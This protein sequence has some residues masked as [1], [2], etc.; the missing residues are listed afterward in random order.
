MVWFFF[1]LNLEDDITSLLITINIKIKLSSECQI[2]FR[3]FA[4]NYFHDTLLKK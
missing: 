2:I 3:T 1:V 4:R